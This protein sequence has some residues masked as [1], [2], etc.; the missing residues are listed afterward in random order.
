MPCESEKSGVEWR[1]LVTSSTTRL[2][3]DIA[4]LIDL[5]LATNKGAQASFGQLTSTLVLV[6]FQVF[7]DTLF[8]GC[9]AD[10]FADKTAD[11]VH[12]FVRFLFKKTPCQHHI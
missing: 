6:V 7:H 8:I 1:G 12:T 2:D 3:Q 11:K 5:P 4:Q 9:K 10:H